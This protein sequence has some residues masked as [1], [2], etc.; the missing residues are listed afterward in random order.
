V[1]QDSSE[2][3]FNSVM[4]IK[5]KTKFKKNFSIF[6]QGKKPAH[7]KYENKKTKKTERFLTRG[8]SR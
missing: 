1:A 4:K 6:L 3:C 5:N 8:E 2:A 7:L